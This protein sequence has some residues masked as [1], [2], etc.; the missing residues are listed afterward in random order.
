MNVFRP[1]PS[2][3]FSLITGYYCS[4]ANTDWLRG[5]KVNTSNIRIT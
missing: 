3:D 2:I 1:V 4:F 5:M